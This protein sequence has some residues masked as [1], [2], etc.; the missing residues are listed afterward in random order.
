MNFNFKNLKMLFK[1]INNPRYLY[2][3]VIGVILISIFV[4]GNSYS[5]KKILEGLENKKDNSIGTTVRDTSSELNK[6]N[7]FANDSFLI[8][9][10]KKD[11]EDLIIKL[12]EYSN[13]LMMYKLISIS[14]S[15]GKYN[16]DSNQNINKFVIGEM[17]KVN[18][19]K[20]FIDSLSTSIKYIDSKA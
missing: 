10:Y 12:E 8:N 20:N 13:N 3:L 7:E 16:A 18:T 17:E 15:A 2:L 9:K 5:G 6:M 4:I 19:I 11:F 14:S 1:Q